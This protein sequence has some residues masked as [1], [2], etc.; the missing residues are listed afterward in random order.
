MVG[1]LNLGRN[2]VDAF[3]AAA[4]LQGAPRKITQNL[5]VVLGLCSAEL[6]SCL[7]LAS[8]GEHTYVLTKAC[9]TLPRARLRTAQPQYWSGFMIRQMPVPRRFSTIEALVSARGAPALRINTTSDT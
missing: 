2:N 4:E 3:T 7:G 5:D 1:R 9:Q 6:C 8:P